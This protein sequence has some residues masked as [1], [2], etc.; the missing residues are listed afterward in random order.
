MKKSILDKLIVSLALV[1]LLLCSWQLNSLAHSLSVLKNEINMTNYT[2]NAIH[3]AFANYSFHNNLSATNYWLK[4]AK[5][6]TDNDVCKIS[7]DK[8]TETIDASMAPIDK[9]GELGKMIISLEPM[10]L[11]KDESTFTRF[12]ALSHDD[13]I[14]EQIKNLIDNLGSYNK[15]VIL[16]KIKKII[17]SVKANDVLLLKL[18]RIKEALVQQTLLSFDSL[19]V[20]AK[21]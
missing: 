15:Y 12:L 8:I 4:I 21:I 16:N 14:N 18:N 19:S 7:I 2:D 6:S 20:C 10:V 17:A 11:H 9:A 5:Q 3:L 13:P 1:W